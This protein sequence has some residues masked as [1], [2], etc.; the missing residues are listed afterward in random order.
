MILYFF[1]HFILVCHQKQGENEKKITLTSR[2]NSWDFYGR[3]GNK[4][5]KFSKWT[6]WTW[7]RLPTGTVPCKM[8]CIPIRTTSFSRTAQLFLNILQGFQVAQQLFIFF[9]IGRNNGGWCEAVSR[10]T[11]GITGTMSVLLLAPSFPGN[12]QGVIVFV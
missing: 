7:E 6:K 9:H 11:C 4:F 1:N 2:N 10:T 5:L 3:T 8:V 12:R